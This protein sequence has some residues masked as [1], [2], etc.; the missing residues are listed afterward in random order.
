MRK[1]YIII[2]L[3]FFLSGCEYSPSKR[4]VV[5][6][7][8]TIENLKLLEKFTEDVSMNKDIKVRVVIYTDE[9]DP[10]I[11]DLNYSNGKIT[12]IYDSRDDEFG[13]QDITESECD[14]IKKIDKNNE[15]LYRLEGCEGNEHGKPVAHFFN[16]RP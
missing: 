16:D 12:S 5:N 10:I 11:H 15:T 7:H 6:M 1:L 3:A 8:G 13:A 4:D 14:S 2:L 9:G